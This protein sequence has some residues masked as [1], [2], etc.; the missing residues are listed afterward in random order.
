MRV[1][2]ISNYRPPIRYRTIERGPNWLTFRLGRFA[3]VIVR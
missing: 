1:N 3:I 2:F